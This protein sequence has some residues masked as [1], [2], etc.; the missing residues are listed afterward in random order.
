MYG[1]NP[2][3][4]SKK[5]WRRPRWT[6]DLTLDFVLGAMLLHCQYTGVS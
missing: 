2:G 5:F 6:D 1:S 4:E 3:Y